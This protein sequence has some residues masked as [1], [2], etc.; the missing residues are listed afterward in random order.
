MLTQTTL[1]SK[2]KFS[3]IENEII[4]TKTP[5]ASFITSFERHNFHQTHIRLNAENKT[6]LLNYYYSVK[7]KITL[8]CPYDF[9]QIRCPKSLL[10]FYFTRKI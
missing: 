5:S 10:M 1:S 7:V 6:V 9:E 3:H 8:M 2:Q 4:S